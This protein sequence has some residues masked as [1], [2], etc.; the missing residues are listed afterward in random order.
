MG[1]PMQHEEVQHEEGDDERVERDPDA[2]IEA[3][4]DIKAQEGS[5]LPNAAFAE[6][7]VHPA[8]LRSGVAGPGGRTD[9]DTCWDYS[10]SS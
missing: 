3:R 5:L 7:L 10:P 1:V 9:G 8:W 4:E 2:K 6:G